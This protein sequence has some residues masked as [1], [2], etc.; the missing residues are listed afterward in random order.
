[1]ALWAI[2]LRLSLNDVRELRGG[3]LILSIMFVPGAPDTPLGA[4]SALC[5]PQIASGL[6][7][8]SDRKLPSIV[9]PSG[10]WNAYLHHQQ[11]SS[12]PI[13]EKHQ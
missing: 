5:I 6:M 13:R 4:V 7:Y 10:V 11:D 12:H 9:H 2:L 3:V 1:M 8:T